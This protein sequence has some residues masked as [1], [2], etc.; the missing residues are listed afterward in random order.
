[1]SAFVPS[2][3]PPGRMARF[4][5][6]TCITASSS[7]GSRCRSTWRTRSRRA[8]STGRPASAASGAWWGKWIALS[9][10]EASPEVQ[11]QLA[12]SLGEARDHK[13]DAAMAALSGRAPDHA[14]LREAVLTGV[15]G[16]ELELA[17]A[18][19]TEADKTN[20]GLL[21]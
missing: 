15:G 20:D 5:F 10:T 4:T 14:F 8:A 7:T 12:L 18:L 19:L 2:T 17:E 6:A 3:S 16:R 1:M 11:L 21:G 9:S 13:A